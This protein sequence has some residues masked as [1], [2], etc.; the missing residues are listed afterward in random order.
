MFSPFLAAVV[1]S[2]SRPTSSRNGPSADSGPKGTSFVETLEVV[3]GTEIAIV[4]SKVAV[5][6]VRYGSQ[7][8]WWYH[9]PAV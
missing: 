5:F 1:V 4:E 8:Q 6:R 7:G 2:S 9:I 3:E